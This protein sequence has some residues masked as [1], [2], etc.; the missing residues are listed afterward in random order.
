MAGHSNAPKTR[1]EFIPVDCSRVGT[2]M[3]DA[4]KLRF[5]E[6]STKLVKIPSSVMIFLNF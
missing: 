6:K 5:S 1:V 2:I 3:A 4:L